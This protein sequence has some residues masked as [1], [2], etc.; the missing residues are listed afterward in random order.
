[1]TAEKK[2]AYGNMRIMA[3]QGKDLF[4][5]EAITALKNGKLN[6]DKF[7][8]II[9]ESLD[10]GKLC[11][12]YKAHEA[13]IGY[14]YLADKKYCRTL[15][16]VSFDYAVKLFEQ[17][18]RR[19]VRY[20]HTVI[21]A[22]MV[23][24]ACVRE[25]SGEPTLIAIEIPYENDKSYAPVEN[26]L[27]TDML[28]KYFEYDAEK[29]EYKRSK[30][31][32][33][34]AVKCEEIREQLYTHGFD[35]DG[36][37]YVRYK[38]SAGSSRDGRCLFIAEPLY[39]DMMAWSACGLSADSVSDQA[40]WQAYIALTLSSIESTIRLPKKA[41]L[42]IPDK[43]S[44]FTTK[45]V[46]V[47]EDAEEGLTATEE[48]TEI[49]NVIWD[50]EALLDVSEF[51]RAGYA[52]KG[53]MLL[54][55]RFFK[56]CAFNTNLQKWFADNGITTVGQLAGYTTARKVDDIKLVITESSLKYLKFMPKG[57][58]LGKAFKSWL[59]NLYEG[60]TISSFGV[61]KTDKYPSLMHGN[62]AYT[63]Y[64]LI[65]TLGIN[66]AG[67]GQLLEQSFEYLGRI[68][69]DPMYLRFHISS[70]SY[71]DSIDGDDL[72]FEN[73]RRRVMLDMLNRTP[74]FAGTDFYKNLRSDVV[75]RFKEKLKQ[76]RIAVAGNYETIFGN[77][78]EFLCAV[79][80][81]S[82]EPTEPLLLSG[83]QVY[84]TRFETGITLA[85]VR[86]PHITMGNLF[87]GNNT[88]CDEI[89]KYFNLT[90]NIICVNAIGNNIQQ[91]L[92]GCDY[93]SDS[94][95]VTSNRWIVRSSMGAY[96]VL[97]IPVCCVAPSG[98]ADYDSTPKSLAMLDKVIANNK[99]GEIVNLSQFLNSLIW[100]DFLGGA[101]VDDV[102]KIYYDVCKLAVLSGMEIDKAKR[103]Y[104]VDTNK[105]L[106]LLKKRK[107]QFK[108]ENGGQVPQ[109]F[110]YIT[111]DERDNTVELDAVINS[112][113]SY[114]YD[115]VSFYSDRSVY[116][117]R[118]PLTEMF[119]LDESNKGENDTHKKQ[120]I[121][122]AVQKAQ[123][124]ILCIK[125]QTRNDRYAEH[126][127]Y[128]EKQEAVFSECLAI[129]SKNIVNDHILAMLLRELD[130]KPT[131]KAKYS[132]RGCRS[133]LFA[134][135]LYGG[136][137][138]LLSRVKKVDGYY[139]EDLLYYREDP[140]TTEFYDIDRIYDYPH[141][142]VHWSTEPMYNEEIE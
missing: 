18:G 45:A 91:R 112:P 65:N 78:Y 43:V 131:D 15:V 134:C 32:I 8:G 98:K 20:G 67:L 38:R 60:K 49:E 21:D 85:C 104:S 117:E 76:G 6:A 106:R 128:A 108:K 42:I 139:P 4:R 86:S 53:M 123:K 90:E 31:D 135:M 47:K 115:I 10:T 5:T 1:M 103:M 34:S 7:D 100:H 33:P 57:M 80:D 132:L 28:G 14:P 46:C 3:I 129:V 111:E 30:K 138:R 92:N 55:N 56:T 141:V 95:L 122:E 58:S 84:T 113:L 93:D 118:I 75:K 22:D 19:F 73:Y 88:A 11:E 127:I 37:H 66:G 119:E 101:T 126:E 83:E 59:D 110:K 99:I 61:V 107:E 116:T 2:K 70:K 26:S 40:S 94:M 137:R 97:G 71:L 62:M 89:D 24:H 12:M 13:E 54:R 64:Q 39:A 63:N 114:L 105:V 9:D 142:K 87:L 82:Y 96:D 109:F 125:M 48:E 136:E 36:I 52:D 51:E 77:P 130:K 102:K 81:K 140:D 41:I 16:N 25:V 23:D 121:I 133:L 35:I 74:L 72:M 120:N 69:N 50:G 68:Q 44:R 17:Y 29:K 79:I 124:Q 27:S